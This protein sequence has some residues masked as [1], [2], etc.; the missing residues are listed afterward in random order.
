VAVAPSEG[1]HPRPLSRARER[2]EK[3]VLSPRIGMDPLPNAD[4]T[5]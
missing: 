5:C 3:H 4:I 2:G 1:P